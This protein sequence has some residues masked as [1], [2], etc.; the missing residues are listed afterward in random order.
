MKPLNLLFDIHKFIP[1]L[2]SLHNGRKPS[3]L[4]AF[5]FTVEKKLQLK[6][7]QMNAHAWTSLV[8]MVKNFFGN[9]QVENKMLVEKVLKSLQDIGANMSI[10]IHFLHSHQDKF[11]DNCGNVINEQGEWFHQDI[12]IMEEHYQWWWDKWMMADFCWSLKRDFNNI[13]HDREREHFYHSFY[14]N[15]GFTSAVSL[16][17]DLMKILVGLGIF[18]HVIFKDLGFDSYCKNSISQKAD[19]YLLV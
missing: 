7:S 10:K 14:V 4:K 3:R 9:C 1:S 8:D 12:K 5:V 2:L 13:E 17:N 6:T 15:K 16:L 11:P 18:H 19:Q